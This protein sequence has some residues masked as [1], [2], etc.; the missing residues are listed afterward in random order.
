MSLFTA[1]P[2]YIFIFHTYRANLW[3][4]RDIWAIKRSQ[5][6][7]REI[8]QK[9]KTIN[10]ISI[11][12]EQQDIK[13]RPLKCVRWHVRKHLHNGLKTHITK[14]FETLNYY[15]H[16]NCL[17]YFFP[18]QN[19]NI[20]RCIRYVHNIIIYWL[21]R[22]T[23]KPIQTKSTSWQEI[24]K[25]PIRNHS[26]HRKSESL[27]YIYIYFTWPSCLNSELARPKLVTI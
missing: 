22:Y 25:H 3:G 1:I 4:G 15:F 14:S 18:E 11:L 21:H 20:I 2:Q 16:V 10:K 6:L 12:S 23:H 19:T 17:K 24:C 7:L 8:S 13:T 26:A 9:P 5:V 27:T